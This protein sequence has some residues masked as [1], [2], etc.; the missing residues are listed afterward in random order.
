MNESIKNTLKVIS[1]VLL[2]IIAVL[3]IYQL[4]KKAKQKD[5]WSILAAMR[6]LDNSQSKMVDVLGDG[7]KFLLYDCPE[8]RR[9]VKSF[10]HDRGYQYVAKYGRSELYDY[11]EGEVIV[12]YNSLFNRYLLC[13]IYDESY[14]LKK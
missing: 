5:F 11:A 1:V 10:L 4:L 13:E 3:S 9:K 6:S 8:S 7:S 12:K 2:G 14:M